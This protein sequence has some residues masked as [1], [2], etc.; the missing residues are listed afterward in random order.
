MGTSLF[1]LI[2]AMGTIFMPMLANLLLSCAI[3]TIFMPMLAK[4]YMFST[5][6]AFVLAKTALCTAKTALCTAK[7]ALCTSKYLSVQPKSKESVQTKKKNLL[8]IW[9]AAHM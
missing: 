5:L 9:P 3:G 6:F 7:T 8:L 1:Y 4:L 2:L